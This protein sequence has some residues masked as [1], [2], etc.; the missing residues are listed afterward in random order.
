MNTVIVI[1]IQV[2]K[3][4]RVLLPIHWDTGTTGTEG[5]SAGT[6]LGQHWDRFGGEGKYSSQRS[7]F[8]FYTWLQYFDPLR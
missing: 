3:S 5:V 4:L 6:E 7:L 2:Q 8:F 1:I